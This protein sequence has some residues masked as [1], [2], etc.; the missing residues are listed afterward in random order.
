VEICPHRA[1][2]RGGAEVRGRAGAFGIWM[3]GDGQGGVP[4][5]RLRDTTGQAY[6]VRGEPVRWKGWRYVTF[7][8]R[9]AADSGQT[10]IPLPDSGAEQ[11]GATGA[12]R[13]MA[14]CIRPS[15]GIATYAVEQSERITSF[16][17]SCPTATGGRWRA[18]FSSPR[19]RWCI[20]GRM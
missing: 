7:P 2:G 4:I 12:A 17:S 15:G 16:R 5:I 11:R 3:H 19:R 8:L 10:M 1:E 6:Q 14:W 20:D 9:P 13:M 18:R